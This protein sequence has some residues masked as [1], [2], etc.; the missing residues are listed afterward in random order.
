MDVSAK[1]QSD[2]S[3]GLKPAKNWKTMLLRWEWMLVIILIIL[4]FVNS[5]VSVNYLNYT[6]LAS[7]LKMFLDKGIIAIPMMMVLLLGEIDISVGSIMALSGVLM[8]FAGSK[9]MPF[10]IILII[11]LGVGLCCGLFNGILVAKFPEL[12]ST[13]ITLGNMIFFR[14]IGYMILENRAYLKYPEIIHFFSWGSVKNVPFIL[15]VFLLEVLVFT[16]II[17]RTR[18]GRSLYAVGSNA[19]AS[20]F[21][22]IG[23]NKVKIIVFG[24]SGLFSGLASI[25]L[26]SKLGSAR[27]SM[28][29]GFEMEIIAMVILGGVAVTGGVGTVLGVALAVFIIGLLRFGLGIINISAENIMI[30]IGMLLIVSVA[31]PNIILA[32]KNFSIDSRIIK[33]FKRGKMARNQTEIKT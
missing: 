3:I 8:G 22:G 25:F 1:F 12:S 31:L 9:D 11:G 2:R 27:A 16:F 19:T 4:N 18:F 15:I 6:N 28:A 17:H 14:G 5:T 13:I 30:I 32:I 23:I 10:S 24:L 21:S 7:T 20:Y 33:Y 26:V 29:I